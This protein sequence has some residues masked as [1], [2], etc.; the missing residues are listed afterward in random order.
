MSK[1]GVQF[2]KIL[3]IELGRFLE[4]WMATQFGSNTP[5]GGLGK[6]LP[7]VN[8]FSENLTVSVPVDQSRKTFLLCSVTRYWSKFFKSCPNRCFLQQ[9]LIVWSFSKPPNKCLKFLG[10]LCKEIRCP[11][12]FKTRPIWTHC[13]CVTCEK[14]IYRIFGSTF[15]F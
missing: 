5:T 15:S 4:Q 14:I 2:G 1:E 12:T 11:R 7:A 6:L 10:Y 9:I 13:S 8:I 3:V